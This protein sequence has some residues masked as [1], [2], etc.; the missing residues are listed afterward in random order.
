MSDKELG[1]SDEDKAQ[2]KK[3]LKAFLLT[4]ISKIPKAKDSVGIED[5]KRVK[6]DLVITLTDGETKKIRLPIQ[7]QFVG[8]GGG[9]SLAQAQIFEYASYYV[10]KA[11]IVPEYRQ[12]HVREELIIDDELILDGDL[13]I[14][15]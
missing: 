7:K 3:E 10:Q 4:E 5:I 11:T 6:D 12:Y 1:V 13:Y 8:G 2:L 15:E 9:I 14:E